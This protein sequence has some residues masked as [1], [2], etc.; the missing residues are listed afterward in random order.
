VAEKNE[1]GV[2]GCSDPVSCEVCD[3]E[4]PQGANAY[5]QEWGEILVRG[6]KV[7]TKT[8]WVLVCVPC[9]EAAGVR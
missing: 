3:T 7:V 4:I 5:Q 9:G 2:R 1:A 8:K 6:T